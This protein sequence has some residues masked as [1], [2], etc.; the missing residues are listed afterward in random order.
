MPANTTSLEFPSCPAPIKP[1]KPDG[2]SPGATREV[3]TDTGPGGRP[4]T[5]LEPAA[6][7]VRLQVSDITPAARE[8]LNGHRGMVAWF[9][10]YPGSGK[11]TVA[12]RL[13]VA[14]HAEGYRTFILDGD[15]IRHGLNNDLGFSDAD[16]VENIRR[17][18]EV[19]RLMVD[20]GLIV[21]AAFISPFRSDREFARSLFDAGQFVE[22]FVDAPLNV[23]EARDPKG[24][25][26]RARSGGLRAMTGIDSPYEPPV[27]PEVH[28][29][30]AKLRA[31]E[32][33]QQ[34]VRHVVA[35]AGPH[36]VARPRGA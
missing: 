17:V 23:C 10:G 19:A 24:L 18:A 12:N 13:E 9:T 3:A 27:A 31:E 16:R 22:V 1:E 26:R 14:L 34:V 7:N 33:A 20:A 25:Y 11:S 36:A 2:N 15:N 32:C 8:H 29:D 4:Y 5:R 30:T 21:I 35:Y 28:L 6:R